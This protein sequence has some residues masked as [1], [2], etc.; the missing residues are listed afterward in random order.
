MAAV[1]DSY[2]VKVFLRDE[3]HPVKVCPPTPTYTRTWLRTPIHGQVQ[4]L[5]PPPSFMAVITTLLPP[6][7]LY[8]TTLKTHAPMQAHEC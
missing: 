7:H 5:S 2:L 3:D 4:L 8:I 1:M 6:P